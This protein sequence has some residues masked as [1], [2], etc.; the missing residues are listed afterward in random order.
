VPVIP[1][2]DWVDEDKYMVE[3]ARM[4][5]LQP[6]LDVIDIL[7][8]E[9][10][11]LQSNPNHK[12]EYIGERRQWLL[13][14]LSVQIVALSLELTDDL[15]A[16][17]M[18]Y[19]E[20][21]KNG[22]KAFIEHL[23]K[24]G[25]GEGHR[26]YEAVTKFRNEAARAVGL[27]PE[28]APPYEI[29][30]VTQRFSEIKDIRDKFWDWYIGYKHG[31]FATPIALTFSARGFEPKQ[32]WGLYL[33]PRPFRRDNATRRVHSEDRFINTVDNLG[34]FYKIA[35]Q[36]VSLSIQTRDRQYPKIYGPWT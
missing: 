8:Q 21:L 29:D 19:M 32:E 25:P 17:C 16:V 24:F 6:K 34:V 3:M 28:R 2:N 5:K 22:D 23:S 10:A 11:E 36:C 15:A 27:D 14:T 4:H 12:P 26:F 31:Q 1:Y 33:I 7:R 35:V 9:F 20:T 18:G 13:A 30:I